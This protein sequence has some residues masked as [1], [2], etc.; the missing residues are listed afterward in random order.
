MYLLHFSTGTVSQN[1]TV[2][3]ISFCFV[4]GLTSLLLNSSSSC[5]IFS[6]GF[7]SGDSAGVFHQ[8]IPCPMMKFQAKLEVC[9]RLWSCMKQCELEYFIWMNGM[10]VWS[11]ISV[12]R[13]LSMMPSKYRFQYGPFSRSLPTHELSQALLYKDNK[14][15]MCLQ[16]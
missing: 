10:S 12:S 16:I 11:R 9:F 6:I 5:H 2:P 4:L 7:K 13:N 8:L 15:C 3:L 14:V 1:C